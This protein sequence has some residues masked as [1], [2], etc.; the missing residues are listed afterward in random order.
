MSIYLIS[1]SFLKEG[2][3]TRAKPL[4]DQ[5]LHKEIVDLIQQAASLGQVTK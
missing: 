4:A 5:E 1:L 2:G 3:L